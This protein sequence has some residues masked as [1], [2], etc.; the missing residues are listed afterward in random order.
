[1]NDETLLIDLGD[2]TIETKVKGQGVR[3]NASELE[4]PALEG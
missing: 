1:M 2:A 3:D 4:I